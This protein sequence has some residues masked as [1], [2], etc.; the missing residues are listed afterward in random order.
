MVLLALYLRA[1]SDASPAGMLLAFGP[2][3]WLV[4]P[5][6]LLAPLAMI[7]GLWTALAAVFGTAVT[8][9]GIADFELP[10]WGAPHTARPAF[11]LV[12]YNTDRSA[13]L[14]AELRV[15]LT[16]WDAD[17]VLLQDCKTIVA[18]SLRAIAPRGL[19]ITAE[20]CLASRFPL[21]GVDSIVSRVRAG[22]A[23][24]GRFGNIVRYRLQIPGGELPVYSVHLESPRSALWAARQ[25]DFARL[26]TSLIV[27][28]ADSEHATKFVARN[29]SAYVVAG[30]F[31]LPY[32]SAILRRDWGDL[33][34][35]FAARG[36]GFGH[37]MWSGRYAVRIDHALTPPTLVPTA[38][39]V[40]RGHPSEHQPL[41][42]DYGWRDRAR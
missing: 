36:T 1:A 33:I 37:T 26:Q 7:G 9:L 24:V 30:D 25:L 16:A 39:R 18:D 23:V 38:V 34:N 8:L 19:S 3:W 27:R 5:W 35:A 31:N 42:V 22:T 11:R 12:T 14:A 4:F 15:D 29:D 10:P 32:G 2:R 20:F 28:A 40:E 41:I 21:V 17:I 6:L 13:L